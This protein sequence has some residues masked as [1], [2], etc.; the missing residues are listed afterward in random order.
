MTP[1]LP[2]TPT[3]RQHAE[4]VIAEELRLGENAGAKARA[5]FRVCEKLR[6]PLTTYAG[7]AGF[8]SLLSRAL[9]LARVEQPW[10][11]GVQITTD[12]SIEY[13]AEAEAQMA[14]EQA[15]EGGTVLVTQ[16]LVLLITFIGEAL[17]FRLVHEVW[18]RAAL[19]E[20]KSG[21][22]QP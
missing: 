3:V 19:K 12:G 13:L 1:N 16:L 14:T 11:G 20:S 15:A 10:L 18:P 17:T 5:A 9:G 21:G 7:A 6:R 4:R 2:E 22:K 8:R